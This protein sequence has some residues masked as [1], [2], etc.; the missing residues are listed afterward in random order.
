[1]LIRSAEKTELES[2]LVLNQANTPHVGS[3]DLARMRHLFEQAAWFLVIE[4]DGETAGFVVAMAQGA[5]YDSPNYTWF[6]SR[7]EE[8][9]YVDRVVVA[10]AQRRKGLAS[11]MYREVEHRARARGIPVFTCEYNLDPPNET[12][13]AFHA[14]Y[15]FEEVGTQQTGGGE[16]TVSLQAK[17]IGE[18]QPG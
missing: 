2:L 12:S 6:Q 3:I 5:D 11:R 16:Y 10:P 9:V 13:A 1:M 4:I 14:R 17:P 18:E 8:F 7:Y 15:G